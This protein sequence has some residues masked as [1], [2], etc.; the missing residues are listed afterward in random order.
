MERVLQNMIF[1][2]HYVLSRD[3]KFQF[4]DT[5]IIEKNQLFSNNILVIKG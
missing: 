2:R 5:G 4:A 3:F 1:G